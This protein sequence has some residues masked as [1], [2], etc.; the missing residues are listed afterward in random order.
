MLGLDQYALTDTATL[1]LLRPDGQGLTIPSPS[2]EKDEAGEDV[3]VHVT[4]ELL[5]SDSKQAV[6]FTHSK[7]NPRLAAVARKGRAKITAEEVA[8]DALDLCVFCTRGWSNM[9]IGG[10]NLAA[11]A[12]NV[13]KIYSDPR[14]SFI[15]DQV[16]D[17]ITEDANF[18]GNSLRS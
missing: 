10:E 18:L 5:R 7:Q 16:K 11:N 9:V 3:Y 17:F 13:R 15:L 8:A 12:A 14:W 6:Q 2:G 4:I 1:K